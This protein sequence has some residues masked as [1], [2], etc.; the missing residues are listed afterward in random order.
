MI[1]SSAP[2][3]VSFSVSCLASSIPSEPQAESMSEL[4]PSS[5]PIR[6]V[7]VICRS[8]STLAQAAIGAAQPP[9]NRL[10]TVRSAATQSLSCRDARASTSS[11][12]SASSDRKVAAI[13]AW[14]GAGKI[15]SSSNH[16]ATSACS[17]NRL[18]PAAASTVAS[19]SPSRTL[20][21]RVGTLPRIGRHCTSGRRFIICIC[22]LGLLVPMIASAGNSCNFKFERDTSTSRASS[23]SST[24]AMEIPAGEVVG[25]SFR[26]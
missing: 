17:P 19:Y 2:D 23:R 13:M 1:K 12:I 10:N 7:S 9:P 18:T 14:P 6:A 21:I 16:W 20:R 8:A 24:G 26:L 22:R 5:N 11:R 15:S 4:F 25:K 3:R